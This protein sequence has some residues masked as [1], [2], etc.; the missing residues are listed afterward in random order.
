VSDGRPLRMAPG[1][2]YV[3]LPQYDARVRI[4]A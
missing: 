3:E 1:Q 2:T 4:G